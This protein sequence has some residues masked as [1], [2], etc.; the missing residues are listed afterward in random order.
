[1]VRRFHIDLHVHT[2]RYSQCAESLDPHMLVQTA[3]NHG[4]DGVVLCEHDVLWTQAEV[5]D[6]ILLT[7]SEVLVYRGVEVTCLEGHF[8]VIGIS[9]MSGIIKGMPLAKL[10]EVVENAQGI[11]VWAHPFRS[12]L[13]SQK[14]AVPKIV[15]LVHAVEVFGS[16]T[17]DLE[18]AFAKKTCL[19]HGKVMVAGSDAH[20]AENVG[21]VFTAFDVLP[22]S[23]TSLAAAI[24][25]GD[26]RPL[27]K[28]I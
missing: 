25:N 5:D 16:S 26:C 11:V 4:L 2:R 7:K 8:V 22:C 17:S 1:M 21:R 15:S 19:D 10:V 3:R 9:D 13:Q 23:E 20:F 6:L 18:E 14:P 28:M 12:G 24:K 27:K